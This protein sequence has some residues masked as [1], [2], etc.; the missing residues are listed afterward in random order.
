MTPAESRH[1]LEELVGT[2]LGTG[3]WMLL[4]ADRIRRFGEAVGRST[5]EV[6]AFMLL[7]LIPDLTSNIA[8][9]IEGPVT[10]INYGL[11]QCRFHKPASA[12]TLVRARATLLGVEDGSGWLQ[13]KREV[14]LEDEEGNAILNAQTLTRMFW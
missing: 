11:D 12:G 14:V 5:D 13:L 10:V 3:D 8:L 4:T 7:A 9:P 2:E 6:P 1:R